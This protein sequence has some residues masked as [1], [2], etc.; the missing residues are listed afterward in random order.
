[1]ERSEV[2]AMA[3]AIAVVNGHPDPDSYA[4][5]VAAEHAAYEQ[6]PNEEPEAG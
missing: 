2:Y 4:E 3:R 1:M 6:Q 5:A